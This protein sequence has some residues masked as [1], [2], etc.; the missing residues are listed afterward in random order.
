MLSGWQLNTIRVA[1]T[2]HQGGSYIASGVVMV[3]IKVTVSQDACQDINCGGRS[4]VRDIIGT[5]VDRE[6]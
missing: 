6:M 3:S 4:A 5:T 2:C 1:I